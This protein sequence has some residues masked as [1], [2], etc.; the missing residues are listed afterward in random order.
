MRAMDAV[1]KLRKQGYSAHFTMDA[2]PNVKIICKQSELEEIKAHLLNDFTESQ[3]ISAKP[4][5]GL[6]K[7]E[8][9]DLLK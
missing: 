7:I 2:G 8:K 5:P 3:L 1:R 4:G 9:P 6:Q